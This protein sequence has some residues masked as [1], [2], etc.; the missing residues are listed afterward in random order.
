MKVCDLPINVAMSTRYVD[1]DV[2]NI[3]VVC[4]NVNHLWW[5]EGISLL[6]FEWGCVPQFPAVPPSWFMSEQTRHPAK[7][8]QCG[9]NKRW[10]SGCENTEGTNVAFGLRRGN[11][12]HILHPFCVHVGRLV[13]ARHNPL[14]TRL[15]DTSCSL[16]SVQTCQECESAAEL[17]KV[18]AALLCSSS[19]L[20]V[21]TG[22]KHHLRKRNN[23]KK[24]KWV[25]RFMRGMIWDHLWFSRSN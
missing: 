8:R 22:A 24:Q 12:Q 20:P 23:F 9:R 6:K 17:C 19:T 18:T 25:W 2:Y 5:R 4:R 21:F 14:V 7:W 1:Y 15:G 3:S 10:Y 13:N 16:W 11:K